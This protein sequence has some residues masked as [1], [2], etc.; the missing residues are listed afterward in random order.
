MEANKEEVIL[1]PSMEEL[2]R[3]VNLA[4]GLVAADT[5]TQAEKR[6]II[7]WLVMVDARSTLD[8][9][10]R[11]TITELKNDIEDTILTPEELLKKIEINAKDPKKFDEFITLFLKKR[12][13]Y[14][15][16]YKVYQEFNAVWEKMITQ[17]GYTPRVDGGRLVI[18]DA[19]GS[20]DASRTASVAR[21]PDIMTLYPKQ[22]TYLR[23]QHDTISR[24]AKERAQNMVAEY[25][26]TLKKGMPTLPVLTDAILA[27]EATKN[28]Y[29]TDVTN[30]GM[31]E[32]DKAIII[33]FLKDP[34]EA[35][36]TFLGTQKATTETKKNIEEA[37]NVSQKSGVDHMVWSRANMERWGRNPGEFVSEFISGMGGWIAPSALYLV[38][39]LF[40]VGHDSLFMKILA[41]AT[42]IGSAKSLGALDGIVDVAT[43]K[44]KMANDAVDSV[45]KAWNT[46]SEDGVVS[47]VKEKF[48]N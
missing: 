37:K 32:A 29:I 8:D 20:L 46:S 10:T 30:S 2:L 43:G 28:I 11:R 31:A 44:S 25:N 23:A 9:A 19:Q 40:G 7:R 45:K 38:L 18:Y 15:P 14:S 22:M 16:E 6:T 3:R 33:H 12:A 1:A 5:T 21:I 4:R 35:E 39:N 26:K 13:T 47:W 41:G 42:V 48:G 17:L 27:S 36:A 24:S 34:R